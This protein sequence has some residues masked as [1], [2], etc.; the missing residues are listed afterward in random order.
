MNPLRPALLSLMIAAAPALAQDDPPA[1]DDS[2]LQMVLHLSDPVTGQAAQ[3]QADSPVRL[4]VRFTDVVTGAPPRGLSPRFFARPAAPGMSTCE[5]AGRAF[6]ATGRTP[7][8]ATG[9]VS[10]LLAYLVEDGAVGVADPRLNL[11]SANMI[12]ALRPSSPP[13]DILADPAQGRLILS[14]PETREVVAM[15]VTG[16]AAQVLASD[17]A[18]PR[19]LA[20]WPDGIAVGVNGGVAVIATDSTV[21]RHA[22][23]AGP[24]RLRGPLAFTGDGVTL[25]DGARLDLGPLAD[26]T[27]AGPGAVLS[28]APDAD[29][30]RLTYTDAPQQPLTIPLG[31]RFSRLDADQAGRVAIAWTPGDGA[32]VLIDLSLG[33]VVQAASLDPGST[34]AEVLMTGDRIHLLSV[35]GGFV[36]LI[37]KSSI[38]PGRSV[39]LSRVMLGGAG[40]LPQGHAAPRLMVPLGPQGPVV[41]IST[42]AETAFVIDPMLALNGQP[43]SD[44]TRLRG[45]RPLRLTAYPRDF[46]EIETA[47]FQTV[48]AFAAGEWELVVTTGPLGITRCLPFTVNGPRA[49]LALPVR[50]IALPDRLR[51]GVDT[52]IALQLIDDSGAPL[53]VPPQLPLRVGSLQ[54]GWRLDTE[55]R[56]T[57]A[58]N[59][60]VLIRLPHAGPFTVVPAALPPGMELRGGASLQ[61]EETAP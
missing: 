45:G 11:Q 4:T 46:T 5:M 44:G 14:Q 34:L 41:A 26:A 29:T 59:M 1:T 15:P 17:L 27:P 51:P 18:D 57:G 39:E 47:R 3:A 20:L 19:D 43:A 10:P 33:Q 21:Q 40:P 30:A 22:L 60:T 9:F 12:A 48:W 23:G 37:Q 42:A 25:L 31:R 16:G 50:V 58:G 2:A 35:D 6:L 54:S 7:A 61:A 36:G 52:V 32:F 28:V 8:G 24:G 13:A 49:A 38:A 56:A 53:P 55:A